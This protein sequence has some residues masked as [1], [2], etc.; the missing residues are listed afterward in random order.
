MK[1]IIYGVSFLALVGIFIIGCQKEN[2]N[3]A[4][5]FSTEKSTSDS[6][7]DGATYKMSARI[8]SWIGSGPGTVEPWCHDTGG[9]C[10]P[11]F[12]VRGEVFNDFNDAITN[13]TQSDYFTSNQVT[14]L[15]D[16]VEPSYIEDFQS[17]LASGDLL[18]L[19]EIAED[20]TNYYI[21]IK[22]ENATLDLEELVGEL[23]EIVIPIQF[24]EE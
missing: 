18:F 19:R 1:K 5:S 6:N 10:L 15:F 17:D 7:I 8:L 20:G 11:E 9:N 22:T 13:A 23:V 4:S 3:P 2:A 24:E 12:I 21:L 14:D 16:M